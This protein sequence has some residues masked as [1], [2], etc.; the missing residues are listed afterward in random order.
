MKVYRFAAAA[1]V[2]VLFSCSKT[3]VQPAG[4]VSASTFTA[5]TVPT[6]ITIDSEWKLSWEVDDAVAI[7]DGSAPKFFVP[8]RMRAGVVRSY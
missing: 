8:E 6:K 2:A 7:N 3:E 5:R 1:I 4:D